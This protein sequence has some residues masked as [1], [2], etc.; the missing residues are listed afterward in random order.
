MKGI[1]FNLLEE[2]V[3]EQHGPDTWD[4]LLDEAAVDGAY[5]SLGSYD[6]AQ[7]RA[8]VGAAS[9]KLDVP[10]NDIVRWFGR[11]AMPMFAASHPHFFAGHADTRAFLLTLNDLIHP[12]VRKLYP[13]AG[14]PDFEYDVSDPE[15]LVM[16]YR[17]A[18]RLCAFAEGLIEGAA[19]Q[20]DQRAAI[21]Q[22]HCMNRG[23][24]HCVLRISLTPA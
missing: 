19:E 12:E 11:G 15:T 4:E 20:Y 18:R 17:S 7:L 3:T 8:L 10:A 13:G 5:T 6:D 14:V 21:E 1:V 2:L 16:R 23:D 22:P 24:D 9:A